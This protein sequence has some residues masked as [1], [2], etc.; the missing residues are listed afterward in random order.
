VRYAS[1]AAHPHA[2]IA[3]GARARAHR[4]RRTRTLI[5]FGSCARVRRTRTLIAGGSCAHMRRPSPAAHA[6]ISGGARARTSPSVHAHA[7]GARARSSPA[8]HVHTSGAHHWRRTRTRVFTLGGGVVA[9]YLA[10]LANLRCSRSFRGRGA[11][12]NGSSASRPARGPCR[13]STCAQSD[14]SQRLRICWICQYEEMNAL[15]GRGAQI[16]I[17]LPWLYMECRC[18]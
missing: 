5:A 8:V 10:R 7:C 9:A 2:R 12:A 11:S 1:P 17:E 15:P 16:L 14:G 18:S 4:R 3:G 13:R 6:R